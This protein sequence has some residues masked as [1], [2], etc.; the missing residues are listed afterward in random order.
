MM[1]GVP[2]E[3]DDDV[4]ELVAL[5]ADLA[6]IHPRIAYGL[7]P[8]VAKR[9][10]PLDGTAFAGIDVVEDRLDRLRRGLAT[11]G[12]AAR[13][14]VRPTSARWAWIEYMLAQGDSSAGLAAMD[15]HRAGGSF[16]AY[17][18]AFAA[19]G[20]APTGPRA[21]VPSSRELVELRRKQRDAS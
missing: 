12:L 13:V 19:R 4:D 3:T 14:E 20:V 2:G 1:L 17:K 6:R 11:A 7:A 21:R 9:N 5:S 8:F 10:T 16:A 15:A 18:K